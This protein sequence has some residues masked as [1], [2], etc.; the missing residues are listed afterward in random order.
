MFGA[1]LILGLG[2][3]YNSCCRCN[4]QYNRCQCYGGYNRYDR[5]CEPNRQRCGYEY[6]YGY[7]C[8]RCESSYQ[9]CGCGGRNRY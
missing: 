7:E 8:G 2:L 3:G 5:C 1:G 9:N 4:N 6:G